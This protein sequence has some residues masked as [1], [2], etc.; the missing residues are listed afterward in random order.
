MHEIGGVGVEV[1]V[2]EEN[3]E[4]HEWAKMREMEEG[5]KVEQ[6]LAERFSEEEVRE[7]RYA[8]LC[9]VMGDKPNKSN[10]QRARQEKRWA[11]DLEIKK[12]K[13]VYAVRRLSVGERFELAEAQMIKGINWDKRD[14]YSEGF[15]YGLA[16]GL[17]KHIQAHEEG[18]A[19]G[20]VTYGR[21]G[22]VHS[23]HDL[24][25][26]TELSEAV[27]DTYYE[28]Q[29]QVYEWVESGSL[30]HVTQADKELLKQY[31]PKQARKFFEYTDQVVRT[32]VSR[33][34][35]RLRK[36]KV[37]LVG[38]CYRVQDVNGRERYTSDEETVR[39]FGIRM[40]AMRETGKW[41]SYLFSDK[42]WEIY[43]LAWFR[44][45]RAADYKRATPSLR[46]SYTPKLLEGCIERGIAKDPINA[47]IVEKSKAAVALRLIKET[48]RK[49][50]AKVW[51][52]GFFGDIAWDGALQGMCEVMA[53][54]WV[55]Q[56]EEA[57]SAQERE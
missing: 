30:I 5:M 48:E 34:L 35:E 16:G 53:E 43:R 38:E 26:L 6:R 33:C 3:G 9:A 27:G 45:L 2:E 40:A 4:A 52:K 13:G 44:G 25:E 14:L 46:L 7:I 31:P 21:W 41:N 10:V 29:D 24:T 37:M 12:E 23:Y 1:E 15:M 28:G 57:E 42:E 8:E 47:L 11:R 36:Q 54:K 17:L 56:G 55:R 39:L 32:I 49:E 18:T 20:A 22:V 51:V 50:V 19:F